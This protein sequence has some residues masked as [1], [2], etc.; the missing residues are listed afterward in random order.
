MVIDFMVM[1]VDMQ[2]RFSTEWFARIEWQV[3]I[4]EFVQLFVGTILSASW[5]TVTA[6]V[7]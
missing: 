4:R 6:D 1:I 7:S 3:F 5:N 2:T